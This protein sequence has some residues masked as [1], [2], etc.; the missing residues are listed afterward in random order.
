MSSTDL[1]RS[2]LAGI[3]VAGFLVS[4][5]V[6]VLIVT[7]SPTPVE[8]LLFGAWRLRHIVLVILLATAAAGALC[9]ALGRG[10]W[11]GFWATV[12]PVAL[13][14][15]ALEGAGRSGL[16]DWA[17]LL[18]PQRGGADAPG[19]TLTPNLDLSG[20]TGQDIATKLGLPHDPIPFSFRTDR[21]GFRNSPGEEGE[22]IVLGDSIVLGA[23]VPAELTVAEVIEDELSAPVMQAALQ[24]ISVQE[25]HELLFASGLPLAGRTVVQFVFE[26]NDLRDS[27]VYRGGGLDAAPV[28]GAARSVSLLR[29]VWNRLTPLSDPPARYST[30]QR[31]GETIGF[32]WTRNSFAGFESEVGAITEA[33]G[34]FRERLE[35]ESARL[36]LVFVP[37]KYRVLHDQCAFPPDSPIADPEANLSEFPAQIS[38]WSAEAGLPLLDLTGPLTEHARSGAS[39]WYWGDTHWSAE[40]HRIAGKAIAAWLRRS[41]YGALRSD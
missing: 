22:I 1:N 15:A 25:Q 29:L 16:V 40:G 14:C 6:G 19:W 35:A 30:C 10:A 23:A 36:L 17:A 24:G 2:R 33:I 21:Y 27:A 8:G 13:F 12:L 38:A 41:P 28:N 18:S 26:G 11:F 34:S 20:Y 37:T 32:L 7:A 3:A 39:P 5:G 9:L 4:L 31:N